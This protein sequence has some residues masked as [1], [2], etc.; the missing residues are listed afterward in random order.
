MLLYPL[1]ISLVI[2]GI[3]S[4]LFKNDPIVYK[5]T[6]ALT[7]IPALFDMI[8][9]TPDMLKNTQFMQAIVSFAEKYI[10]LFNLGFGW[11]M[12]SILGLVIGLIIHFVRS[13]KSLKT[14]ED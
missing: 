12:F 11:L 1:A 6:T 8:N 4:P 3:L 9:S 7:L 2:L 14:I 13:E 5:V 10:P